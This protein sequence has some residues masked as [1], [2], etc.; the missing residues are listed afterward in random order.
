MREKL[1]VATRGQTHRATSRAKSTHK[2]GGCDLVQQKDIK[3]QHTQR[4]ANETQTNMWRGLLILLCCCCCLASC[5]EDQLQ[6]SKIV[7]GTVA[8]KGEFPYAVSLRRSKSGHHS[9]GGTL[10]NA[11]WVLTA[12]HCVRSAN[13]QDV[14]VQYGSNI[15]ARNATQLAMVQAIFVHPGYE[16]Q[17]KHFNDIALLQLQ[18]PLI[19]DALV[20]PVRLPNAE[21]M[22]LANSS[23]VLAGW[24][25]N[26]T[27]GVVQ[28]QLMKVQLQ[29]FSDQDCSNL[30]QV[31]L[32]AT[33]LCAGV[34]EGGKGQCSGDSGGPLLLAGSDTQV[35]IVSWSIKP[36]TRP[37]YPGVFTEVSA[38]VDWIVATVA[39][40][41]NNDPATS[42]L[43]IGELIV[44]RVPPP[45][46]A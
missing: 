24:G 2:T 3:C 46:V 42:Q 38:Y 1:M 41:P 26:A 23:V 15:I 22:T 36:C 35:G 32:H 16:P 11:G 25:L 20:Q 13:P 45:L 43:W 5:L 37:P 12:A 33:Q 29:A 7:N 17:N 8:A 21:Q 39:T 10:L 4:T 31:Q 19:L 28:Q 34:P 6:D 14:N 18:Q 40:A 27:G 9:C 30:H 44:A